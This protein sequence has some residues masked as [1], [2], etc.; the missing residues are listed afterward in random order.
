VKEL[1][2]IIEGEIRFS[3]VVKSK[4]AGQ[5]D[6]IIYQFEKETER[7][8]TFI[9]CSDRTGTTNA[10]KG[11]FVRWQVEPWGKVNGK[12]AEVNYMYVGPADEKISAKGVTI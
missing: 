8:L 10:K 4:E 3:S 1:K 12:Y 7:K 5:K 2:V 6:L 9:V 11:D